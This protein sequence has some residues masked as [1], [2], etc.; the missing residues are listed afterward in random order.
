[1][2]GASGSV[3]GHSTT[4]FLDQGGGDGIA[5]LNDV[6]ATSP[7]GPRIVIAKGGVVAGGAGSFLTGGGDGV[8]YVGYL[9]NAGEIT[10]GASTVSVGGS[11]V[12]IL[13][14]TSTSVNT[15]KIVGGASSSG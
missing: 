11:G 12:D 2:V 14:G 7:A 15:G 3:A 6:F 9:N 5:G 4:T 8:R 13:S 10:G 1:M